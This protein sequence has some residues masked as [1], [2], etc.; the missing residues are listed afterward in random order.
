[1]AGSCSKQDCSFAHGRQELRPRRMG[2]PGKVSQ[3]GPPPGLELLGAGGMEP[4]P[5]RGQMM[6]PCWSLCLLLLGFQ[7]IYS[8][9]SSTPREL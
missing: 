6:M 4:V 7:A 1:M 8:A 5:S 9:I 3:I 2:Q